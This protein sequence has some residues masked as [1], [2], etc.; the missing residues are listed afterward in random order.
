[1]AD[2]LDR[3]GQRFGDYRLLRR[4]GGGGF[5]D[6][7]LGEHIHEQTPAA[8]KILH[9]KL[10]R[11]EDLLEFINEARTMRLKHPHIISLLD[12]GIGK[13]DTPFLVMTYAP[14]G[15]LRDLHPKGS[16]L[17]LSTIS[18]YVRQ[19]SSALQYA[20][21]LH[22]IHRD[23]KPENMLVGPTMLMGP[24]HEVLLSDFGIVTVAQSSRS[25]T[26]EQGI[27]GTLPYMAPEQLAGRPRAASDQYAM[28]VVVYEWIVGRRPFNGTAAEIAM[29]HTMTPPPSLREQLPSLSIDVEQVV[30]RALAK[31]PMSRF[32]NIEAFAK[33]FEQA[34]MPKL[35]PEHF[36]SVLSPLP[37]Q[38]SLSTRPLADQ[39]KAVDP[40]V[41]DISSSPLSVV[42]FSEAEG[43]ASSIM[44]PV[45][46]PI[47]T[48]I[49]APAASALFGQE[50][51]TLRFL[52]P[53]STGKPQEPHHPRTAWREMADVTDSNVGVS[54]RKTKHRP[55]LVIGLVLLALALTGGGLAYGM[56]VLLNNLLGSAT[57][58]ITPASKDLKSTYDFLAVTRILGASQNQVSARLL[59][60]STS[61][62][63]KMVQATG[64]KSVPGS[65][66]QASGQ[67]NFSNYSASPM[68]FNAGMVLTDAS[69]PN[70]QV[71]LDGTG[72]A[73]AV[74]NS[75]PGSVNVPA[76]VVQIGT[77]GNLSM[78]SFNA[79]LGSYCSSPQFNSMS[80]C[81]GLYQVSCVDVTNWSDLTGGTDPQTYTIVQQ[82]NI[83]GAANTLIKANSPD[84]Q[85]VLQ[86]RIHVN[87]RL[88]GTPQCAPHVKSD[89]AVGD[90]ATSVTVTVTFTCDGEVYEQD[91][92]QTLATKLL[93]DEGS[94]NMGP[95]YA[96]E[97]KVVTSLI[98][99]NVLD[100]KQGTVA[101]TMNAEGTWV[102]QFNNAQKQSLAHSIAGKTKQVAYTLLLSQNGVLRANIQVSGN[103]S[104]TLPADPGRITIVVQG[105]PAAPHT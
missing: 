78:D 31:D 95:S 10:A 53:V 55:L 82:S 27:G 44:Q 23:V 96:L 103:N 49:P 61:A 13:D 14:H 28:G 45:D 80:G 87:E 9:T 60:I 43:L 32:A 65:G 68:T 88:I 58:T 56:P 105:V 69:S 85:K 42:S 16:R 104:N 36:P 81:R 6:V 17:P 67:M 74:G 11:R 51:S 63:T 50:L 90:K 75:G 34:E 22:L 8:V 66:T 48:P 92:A 33:A 77:I 20:H 79:C 40:V 62:Q 30:L 15:T 46:R 73:Q 99:A 1:M 76:H 19:V 54:R 97:G 52:S 64:T 84:L 21:S 83:D 35:P 57:V 26:T 72:T 38:E 25:L 101:L 93:T 41:M 39:A 71:M 86:P 91:Q 70:I 12:F 18:S 59:S 29:Q 7:Y 94:N 24:N 3:V 4:L 100:A 89:H 5:G 2:H 98:K 47:T 102:S 37:V